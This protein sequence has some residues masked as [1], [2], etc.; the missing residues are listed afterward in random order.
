MD[1]DQSKITTGTKQRRTKN[2]RFKTDKK[3]LSIRNKLQSED[4]PIHL[5]KSVIV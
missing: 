3:D 1:L 4:G 5:E 2:E